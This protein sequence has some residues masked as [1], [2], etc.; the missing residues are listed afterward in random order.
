M[1]IDPATPESDLHGYWLVMDAKERCFQGPHLKYLLGVGLPGALVVVVGVPAFIISCMKYYGAKNMLDDPRVI[2]KFGFM[3][4]GYKCVPSPNISNTSLICEQCRPDSTP[5]FAAPRLCCRPETAWWEAVRELA[6]SLCLYFWPPRKIKVLTRSSPSA[7]VDYHAQEDRARRHQ[8]IPRGHQRRGHQPSA[9]HDV[10]HPLLLPR[11]TDGLLPTQQL[12]RVLSRAPARMPRA[13]SPAFF[14]ATDFSLFRFRSCTVSSAFRSSDLSSQWCAVEEAPPSLPVSLPA[15]AAAARYLR[16]VTPLTT[17]RFL[18]QYCGTF[19]YGAAKDDA[20]MQILLSGILISF[21]GGIIFYFVLMVLKE[22]VR[23]KLGLEKISRKQMQ[24]FLEERAWG[25]F[26]LRDGL[27]PTFCKGVIL[28]LVWRLEMALNKRTF[29][30]ERTLARLTASFEHNTLVANARER[31]RRS[32]KIATWLVHGA[33]NSMELCERVSTYEARGRSGAKLFEICGER[34]RRYKDLLALFRATPEN[35][36]EEARA[37]RS[38]SASLGPSL[39]QQ[40]SCIR[41]ALRA[42]S[43]C[44]SCS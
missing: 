38:A 40:S 30:K 35:L 28:Q 17:R 27:W 10:R 26:A 2:A 3:F 12:E 23:E 29:P 14:A 33:I 32:L 36:R 39:V 34:S 16:C 21:N 41:R 8:R 25:A 31:Q 11:R 7:F 1:E 15:A 22:V 13:S 5:L 37:L 42:R 43:G 24:L 6:F 19:F 44:R 20:V 18:L 4:Y 9:Q